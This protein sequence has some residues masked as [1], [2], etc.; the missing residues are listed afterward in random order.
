ME[1]DPYAILPA[2]PKIPSVAS[3]A[4]DEYLQSL[5]LNIIFQARIVT[6]QL[7]RTMYPSALIGETVRLY[8]PDHKSFNN[9]LHDGIL[10]R[11]GVTTRDAVRTFKLVAK[12][13][14]EVVFESEFMCFEEQWE[15]ALSELRKKGVG[16]KGEGGLRSADNVR[17]LVGLDC[18]TY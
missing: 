9:L 14:G 15:A 7:T 13:S 18:E 2:A 3:A 6:S 8:Y 10:R 11:L 12:K 16:K 5:P 17:L 4:Y 1:M